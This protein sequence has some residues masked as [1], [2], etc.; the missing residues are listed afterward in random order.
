MGEPVEKADG[1][2]THKESCPL[3]GER[4]KLSEEIGGYLAGA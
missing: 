3:F 2:L 4:E 1:I